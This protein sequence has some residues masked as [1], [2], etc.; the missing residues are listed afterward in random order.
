MKRFLL[1]LLA[2]LSISLLS[3]PTVQGKVIER[4]LYCGAGTHDKPELQTV[5]RDCKITATYGY[6]FDIR[7]LD[8]GQWVGRDPSDKTKWIPADPPEGDCTNN[9]NFTKTTADAIHIV[10]HVRADSNNGY[11][12]GGWKKFTVPEVPGM[13]K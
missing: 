7:Y 10:I 12:C 11:N 1:I 8:D 13:P 4:T 6:H 2:I 5:Q 3:A 9:V